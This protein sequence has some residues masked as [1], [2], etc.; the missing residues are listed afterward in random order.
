MNGN[1]KPP[2]DDP[3]GVT[4]DVCGATT[5]VEFPKRPKARDT[6][7]LTMVQ[8]D[9]GCRHLQVIVDEKKA[10]VECA[11]CHEKLNPIWVL[12]QYAREDDRLVNRWASLRAE[13]RLLQDRVRTTCQ[14]CQ[15]MTRITSSVG[16]YALQDLVEKIKREEGP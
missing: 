3:L 1:D 7:P 8:F 13:A 16:A 12:G 6:K 5:V 10:E 11:H 15:K 9:G 4:M 14:H 2:T